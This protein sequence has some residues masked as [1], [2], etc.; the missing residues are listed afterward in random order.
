MV[1]EKKSSKY[2]IGKVHD[3]I[4]TMTLPTK[5][6][7]GSYDN[8]KQKLLQKYGF[9]EPTR[10]TPPGFQK[11][12]KGMLPAQEPVSSGSGTPDATSLDHGESVGLPEFEPIVDE[13]P[14]GLADDDWLST[15]DLLEVEVTWE[16]PQECI[17]TQDAAD[18]V[19]FEEVPSFEPIPQRDRNARASQRRARSN[20]RH[21]QKRLRRELNQKVKQERQVYLQQEKQALRLKKLEGRKR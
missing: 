14:T 11:N 20:E 3:F 13:R 18:L 15:Y 7:P 10:P 12:D 17:R 19:S 6:G 21:T 5:G 2:D 9:D 1:S 8:L 4:D 16:T